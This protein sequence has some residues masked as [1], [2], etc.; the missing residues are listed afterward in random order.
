[1]HDQLD[2]LVA[3]LYCRCV[4]C[5]LQLRDALRPHGREPCV[6]G[7]PHKHPPSLSPRS[8]RDGK[9]FLILSSLESN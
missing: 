1:M 7:P 5:V 8:R 2:E 6:F 9:H 3:A 4:E